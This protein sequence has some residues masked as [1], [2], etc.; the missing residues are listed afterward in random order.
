MD[1]EGASSVCDFLISS[2]SETSKPA[3]SSLPMFLIMVNGGIPGAMLRLS[4][5][6]TRL[7]RAVDNTYPLAE[8]S[9]SR[10]HAQLS[11]D[12]QGVVRLTD[13]A[14]VNGTFL[15]GRRL[16]P[17]TPTRLQ[18]GDR[19][20]LGSAVVL[21]FVRLD[22]CDEQFQRELFERIVRDGLTGLY[23]RAYFLNQ[24]AS[25]A[26]FAAVHGLGLAVL[27]VDIDHFKRVNDTYGHG[28][29]DHVLREVAGVLRESTR[30]ED[31]V[32]RYG[33]EEFVVAVPVAAPDQATERA[34]R[35][36]VNLAERR[37]VTDRA[38]LRVTASVGLAFA[39][40]GTF[41][42][43]AALIAAADGGLYQAKRTG[44]D[45]VVFRYD[46]A[47]SPLELGGTLSD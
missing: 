3:S 12:P 5:E 43:A 39:E 47:P 7:G 9:V 28:A 46:S 6:G 45:R 33:G 11:V 10:H 24:V 29:G 21:K 8:G 18:D 40:P 34:E 36:R 26:G 20:Q 35:I 31:L 41:R 15:N 19:V 23:N 32:A 13:L 14:S 30:T 37:I 1:E 42:S 25:L 38:L 17:H 27:M 22:P 16:V 44:R 2:A 4:A